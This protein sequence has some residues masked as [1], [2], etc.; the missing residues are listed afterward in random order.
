MIFLTIGGCLYWRQTDLVLTGALFVLGELAL[1]NYLNLVK[2]ELWKKFNIS[3][4]GVKKLK[5]YS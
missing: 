3:Q 4:K 2:K 1:K 5:H